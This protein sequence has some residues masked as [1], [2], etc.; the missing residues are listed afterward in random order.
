MWREYRN[1]VNVKKPV[2][3]CITNYVTVNDCANV[4][5]AANASPIM[6]DEIKEVGDIVKL[7]DA[8]VINIGTLNQ[9]KVAAM[10]EAGQSANKR[11]VPVILDPVGVGASGYRK[12]VVK[13][14]L[15]KIDFA[16]I[17]GNISELKVIVDFTGK[18]RGVDALEDDCL[19]QRN[20]AIT[21]AKM[22]DLSR[23]Y[24]CV[25]AIS[26]AVDLLCDCQDAYLLY[27]G[28][29]AMSKITGTGCMLSALV[30][31]FIASNDDHLQAAVAGFLLMGIAGEAAYMKMIQNK[32]GFASMKRYLI[33]SIATTTNEVLGSQASYLKYLPLDLSL[34]GITDSKIMKDLGQDSRSSIKGGVSIL[35]YRQKEAPW[36]Q[37]VEEAQKLEA[38]CN[39]HQ[40]PLVINDSLELFKQCQASGIHIGQNDGDCRKIRSL[41]GD[42]KII[43]VS[44]HSVQEAVLAQRQGAN[45]LGVGAMELTPTKA[46]AGKVSLETL[47]Q[48]VK[49]VVIPVVVIGGINATNIE[50]YPNVKGYALI[51]GI[52]GSGDIEANCKQLKIKIGE[53]QNA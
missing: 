34:Y 2:V 37:K 17:R 11:N 38:I 9:A 3:H 14:M 31:A 45:Y 32:E 33:D 49:N 18:T 6:A 44:C 5:L 46:N 1:R 20:L 23:R 13:E 47:E 51:R 53:I 10:I 28:H 25:I 27:N 43:G 16:V 39:E 36:L 50:K 19:N 8:L 12:E 21:I 52:Y 35:Q 24:G 26:G 41:I 30:G 22:Q 40:V 42:D 29:H 48:I 4:L 7:A 15:D